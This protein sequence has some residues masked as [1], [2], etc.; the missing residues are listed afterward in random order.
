MNATTRSRFKECLEFLMNFKTNNPNYKKKFVKLSK[1]I[2]SSQLDSAKVKNFIQIFDSLEDRSRPIL[3]VFAD[4]DTENREEIDI[5]KLLIRRV[6]NFREGFSR[7]SSKTNNLTLVPY[8]LS[9]I[10][11]TLV[12]INERMNVS[13]AFGN[14]TFFSN[15]LFFF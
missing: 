10:Y 3:H 8:L 2:P 7:I 6:E 12:N 4:I 11:Q 14:E 1:K 5:I 13:A 9:D 15:I